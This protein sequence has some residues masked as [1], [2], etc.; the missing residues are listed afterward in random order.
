L[1]IL[2]VPSQLACFTQ[3]L[4]AVKQGLPA[5][6]THLP[7][8]SV[9][10]ATVGGVVV[11]VDLIR[12]FMKLDALDAAF[13]IEADGPEVDEASGT[14]HTLLGSAQTHL[15]LR[16]TNP[17]AETHPS[18]ESFC[19]NKFATCD[20]KEHASPWIFWPSCNPK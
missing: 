8:R 2:G 1:H 13:E 17:L 20:L 14:S 16:H 5:L 3:V 18:G 15:L 19:R 10:T 7:P 12:F 6:P 9:G 11:V 4:L